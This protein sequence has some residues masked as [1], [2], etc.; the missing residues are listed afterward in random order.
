MLFIITG[1]SGSGK[2]TI[3]RHVFKD[4][5]KVE[6]SISHTTRSPRDSEK[7][8]REYH[9]VSEAE[10]KRMIARGAFVE[11]AV[12]HDHHYGTSK[13]EI[14]RKSRSSDVLLDIDVQGARQIRDRVAGAVFVFILPPRYAE[15][16]RRLV[17]RGQDDPDRIR[18]RLKNAKA[19]IRE[20]E[21]FDFIVINERLDHA[22]L[23][24]EAIILSSR[25]RADARKR[26][27]RSVLDSLKSR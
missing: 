22:V 15:L 3:L 1:P 8:G 2:S 5:R 13:S 10:F 23:E 14:R 26:A 27:V 4:M 19:E 6:F 11:W 25:C 18:T 7:D 12:V 17:E 24:L 20:A 21:K 9:F 16:R